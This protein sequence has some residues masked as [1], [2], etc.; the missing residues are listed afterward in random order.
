MK[1][2]KFAAAVA[3][4]FTAVLAHAKT[5]EKTSGTKRPPMEV[6]EAAL[7]GKPSLAFQY[8]LAQPG[9]PTFF[10][11]PG[12]NRATLLNDPAVEGLIRQ[13]SGVITFNFSVQPFSIAE[14]PKDR[15]VNLKDITLERLAEET[16]AMARK[17]EKEHGLA[18]KD[19]IPVTLSYSAAVSP[20]LTEFPTIIDMVPM[21]SLAAQNPTLQA[22]ISTLKAAELWNPIFGP[23]ITRSTLD[24]AYRF[25]W[26]KQVDSLIKGF[27][28][29]SNR[30]TEMIEGYM[31][32]SRAVEGFSWE[33]TKP[34]KKVKRVFVL[35][36][37]EARELLKDQVRTILDLKSKGYDVSV[38]FVAESGHIL[39]ADQPIAYVA[40]LMAVA[41]NNLPEGAAALIDV[42]KGSAITIE[43]EK[44]IEFL[45][46]ILK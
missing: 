9:K 40:A 6:C 5:E 31:T 15:S 45:K 42:K 13:G 20:Y 21:T 34:S 43:G 33:K 32:L 28:L 39:P 7:T 11:L 18:I 41:T 26:S 8:V 35:A 4:T 1:L 12:V 25:E 27:D 14:L 10:L 46:A 37:N 2:W 44:A 23:G 30:R 24:N 22:S 36:E 29:P 16:M 19:M 3:L 38:I 17:I